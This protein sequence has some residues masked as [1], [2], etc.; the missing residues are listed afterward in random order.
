MDEAQNETTPLLRREEVDKVEV[1]PVIHQI[2]SDIIVSYLVSE[3]IFALTV[4]PTA[5]HR[6][7]LYIYNV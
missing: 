7:T 3:R 5:L 2:K 6:Y 1:Y 4:Y